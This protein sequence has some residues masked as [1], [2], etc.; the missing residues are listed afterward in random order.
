MED[1]DEDMEEKA[2]P[3][4]TESYVNLRKKMASRHNHKIDNLLEGNGKLQRDFRQ[5]QVEAARITP[6]L[7]SLLSQSIN[8]S[9]RFQ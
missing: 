8:R 6:R 1:Q 7:V 2:V 9:M 3:V 5:R 4:E